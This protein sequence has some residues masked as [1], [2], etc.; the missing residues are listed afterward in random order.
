MFAGMPVVS[1]DYWNLMF[2]KDSL[3]PEDDFGRKI[4]ETLGRRMAEMVLLL[5]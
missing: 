3:I 1:S 2:P 4:L 5:R